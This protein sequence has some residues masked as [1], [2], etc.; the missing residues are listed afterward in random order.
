MRTDLT[1]AFIAAK[2][3]AR[4][5]PRELLVFQF[6]VAGNKYI[7]DQQI[8]L[9]GVTYQALV[10][11]WGTLEDSAGVETENSAEVLQMSTGK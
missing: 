3:A 2:N 6:P 7:S 4:R 9:G 5:K 8:E 1:A 10:E 11:D